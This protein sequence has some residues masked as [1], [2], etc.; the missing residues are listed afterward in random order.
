MKLISIFL[1]SLIITNNAY[2]AVTCTGTVE[3]VYTWNDF[4]HLSILIKT[5]SGLTNWVNMTSQ[6]EE[7]L[8]L[9]AFATQKP[10]TLYMSQATNNNCIDGWTHN[11]KLD[12]YF[13]IENS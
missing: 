2:S 9:M 7:S 11:T 12:G 13:Q 1:L 8:A 4:T 6:S 10:V 5:Q 3:R